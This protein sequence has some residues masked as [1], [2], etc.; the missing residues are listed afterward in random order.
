[1]NV[2]RMVLPHCT[3]GGSIRSIKSWAWLEDAVANIPA[4]VTSP[5]A[6]NEMARGMPGMIYLVGEA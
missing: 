4:T 3:T 2:T 6:S 5:F 1:M